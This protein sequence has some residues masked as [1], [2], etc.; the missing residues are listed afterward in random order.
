MDIHKNAR[1]TPHSRTLIVQCLQAG[2]T[3]ARVAAGL[4]IGRASFA[5][6]A[7]ASLKAQSDCRIAPR[8][9]HTIE[10]ATDMERLR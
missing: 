1:T 6:G 4:G 10:A 9:S 2:L 7:T 3:V 5:S 8:A